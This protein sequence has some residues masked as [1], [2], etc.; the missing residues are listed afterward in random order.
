MHYVTITAVLFWHEKKKGELG[1]CCGLPFPWTM[2]FANFLL[3][4][5]L[6]YIAEKDEVRVI[7]KI[8]RF[9]KK[10]RYEL[11][12]WFGT[13]YCF[14]PSRY[15]RSYADGNWF[16]ILSTFDPYADGNPKIWPDVRNSQILALM[17]GRFLH[18]DPTYQLIFRGRFVRLADKT[19]FR[20]TF[21]PHKGPG[22]Q[23][24]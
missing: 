17:Y 24:G 6:Q 18:R 4:H 16:Q 19:L 22:V 10:R 8:T 12:G 20:T 23:F 1:V 2:S 11:K 21:R 15:A 14:M 13:R 3:V 5:R 9:R 7:E